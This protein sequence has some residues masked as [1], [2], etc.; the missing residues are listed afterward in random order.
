MLGAFTHVSQKSYWPTQIQAAYHSKAIIWEGVKLIQWPA[1]WKTGDMGIKS[2]SWSC[3]KVVIGRERQ[4]RAERLWAE[5]DLHH[6][7][8]VSPFFFSG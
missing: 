3:E 4:V 1:S 7:G 2:P 6:P 5:W 8:H